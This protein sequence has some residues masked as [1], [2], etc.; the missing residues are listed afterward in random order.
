MRRTTIFAI[1]LVFA[2]TPAF[3]Q[4]K[5][6]KAPAAGIETKQGTQEASAAAASAG[7]QDD[8]ENKGPWKALNYRLV[9]PYR[10]GRVLAVSGV[11]GQDNNY[12]FGGVAGGVWKTTDSGLNWEPMFDKQKD[13]WPSICALAGS[14]AGPT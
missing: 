12:Y 10:G 6:S 3:A 9:G 5:K 7:Q 2:I 13:S 11:V 8:E 14:E 1:L 4:K